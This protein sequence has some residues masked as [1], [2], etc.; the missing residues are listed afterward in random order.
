MFN[1]D[2][3]LFRATAVFQGDDETR[4]YL[5]GVHI[6]PHPKGGAIM[7]ATDGYRLFAAHDPT[8]ACGGPARIVHLDAATLAVKRPRGQK[9]ANRIIGGEVSEPVRVE[10]DSGVIALYPN[11]NVDGVFPNWR[12]LLPKAEPKPVFAWYN[13][14]L[15]ADFAKAARFISERDIPIMISGDGW[16]APALIRLSGIGNV[17]GMLMPMQGDAERGLPAFAK[18]LIQ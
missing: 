12:L 9:N 3:S 17:F 13:S 4:Y 2:A 18:E 8:G 15:L 16:E 10:S 5:T 7:V 14:R 1:V 6:E 11:W